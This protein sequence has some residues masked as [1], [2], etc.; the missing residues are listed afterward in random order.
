MPCST[1]SRPH[2]LDLPAPQAP[3]ARRPPEQTDRRCAASTG[4]RSSPRYPFPLDRF[5]LEAID[6]L[7]AGHHVVVAAPTGSGKTV[8]AEYGIEIDPARRPAGLLHRADQ[9]AV[10]PEV[11]RPRRALRRRRGRS[12]HR[13][14]RHRRRRAG[15]RDDHRGAAQHDLRPVAGAR[16]PRARRARRGAL[17]AGHLPRPGVGGGD[18]PPARRT[19]GWCACRRRSATPASWRRGSRPSAARPRRSSSCAARCA[20]T[21]ATSSATAPTTG[22]TCCETFDGGRPNPEAARL[23]ASAVRRGAAAAASGRSGQRPAGAR[24]RRAGSRSSTC[25]TSAACCRRSYFIFSR[26]QCDEAARTCLAAGLRLTTAPSATASGRSS[27][28]GSRGSADD[29]LA[30]LGYGQFLAQLEAGIAAHHAG[31]VPAFKEAVE[32]CFIEG[33]IKVV[34]ATETLAVGINMPARTVVIEKLTK[35]TGDHHEVA[36]AGGVH[37]AHR[38]GRAARASTRRATPSCCGARSCR[39]SRSPRWPPAGRSTSA[40]RSARRTTWPPTSSARTPASRPTTCSTC[41]SPS[42]RPTATSCGSR[43]A[44]SG[45]GRTSARP[46]RQAESPYGDIWEYRRPLDE[47]PAPPPRA[48][49]TSVAVGMARLRPGEVVHADKGR[50]RGPVAVVASAHRKGGMRLT[51][52][53]TRADLLLLTRRRLRRRPPPARHGPAAGGVQPEPASSTAARSPG[54][55]AGRSCGRPRPVAAGTGD[56]DAAAPGRVRPGSARSGCGPPG[57]PS[58]SS[59]SSSSSAAASTGHNQLARPR[60]RPGARRPRPAR[61]RRR[62]DGDGVAADRTPA[63]CSLAAVPRVATCW[64]PSASA[65]GCSTGSTRRASPGCCRRSCTSTAAP[66]RRRRRG[67]RRGRA[68][69]GGG[70]SPATSEEL[71]ADERAAGLAEHRPPDPGFVAAAY[72]WVAGEGLAEVVGDEELTGGDFVR[73]MKQLVDLARQLALVAPDAGDPRGAPARSASG[74]SAASSPTSSSASP[75]VD[76]EPTSTR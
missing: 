22:C 21:T 3:Q 12:A 65:T 69:S 73:T 72:A 23:D 35:F 74:R 19:S 51:T 16:R 70:G 30:V 46:A 50:Y 5:Q 36:D 57:R 20:S 76:G 60:L 41:R 71:A 55:S 61:L 66:S 53:T 33:L 11:P 15:R 17:P 37:P 48:A 32:A 34:F 6:A 62:G 75:D 14:Q 8:V 38:T 7:D 52:V 42:T 54:R 59:A 67:S 13:R 64:S 43:P 58:G 18:H 28:P 4:P 31:M 2:R 26:N 45:C 1:S 49:T 29:D 40:R 9:G 56:S 44:S 25:S 10:E 68:R 27:T 39:S 47:L 63:R 24:T